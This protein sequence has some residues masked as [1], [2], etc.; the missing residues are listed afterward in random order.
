MPDSASVRSAHRS[1]PVL[2]RSVPAAA[3][4]G[5]RGPTPIRVARFGSRRHRARRSGS[6]GSCPVAVA[7][8]FRELARVRGGQHD[9]LAVR[10]G[11][12]GDEPFGRD[13]AHGRVRVHQHAVALPRLAHAG[14]GVGVA[15]GAAVD[16]GGHRRRDRR[17]THPA[18]RSKLLGLPT[19]IALDR[20]ASEARGT[21]RP[22]SRYRGTSSFALVAAT[23]RATGRPQRH[24]YT[25][26][27]RWPK[28]PLGTQNTGPRA[29][30]PDPRRGCAA[31]TVDP[32]SRACARPRRTR[33]PAAGAGRC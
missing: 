17:R 22:V 19:S 9:H 7:H 23:K 24:A 10:A 29:A 16:G 1:V 26:A 4:A 13:A 12:R 8:G 18:S 15:H 21:N 33:T 5:R 11:A 6:S 14:P 25:P 30:A 28:L 2:S 31:R 27:V 20:V 32:V 3:R